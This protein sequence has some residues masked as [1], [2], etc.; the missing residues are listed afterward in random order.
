MERIC[1]ASL[2]SAVV[3]FSKPVN[4]G[5]FDVHVEL[6]Q[7]RIEVGF[8]KMIGNCNDKIDDGNVHEDR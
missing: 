5:S 6:N 1:H 4:K 8:E 3:G 2:H 7:N